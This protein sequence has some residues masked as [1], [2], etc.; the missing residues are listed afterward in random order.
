MWAWLWVCAFVFRCRAGVLEWWASRCLE[1][2]C[3]GRSSLHLGRL[4]INFIKRK[5]KNKVFCTLSRLYME[6]TPSEQRKKPLEKAALRAAV[7]E[8]VLPEDLGSIPSSHLVWLTS[9]CNSRSRRI[10]HRLTFTG[11]HVC[12]R[13]CTRE[14]KKYIFKGCSSN[15]ILGEVIT[16]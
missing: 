7:G 1:Y 10:Q 15:F 8:S 13:A 11:V 6:L 2:D 12:V 4:L 5:K 9:A 16:S 3:G 14:L